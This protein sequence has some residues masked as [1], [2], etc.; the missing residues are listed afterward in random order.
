MSNGLTAL[1]SYTWSKS[2]DQSSA[3]R[4]NNTDIFT[5]DA[6]CIGCDYG[7]S[8]FNTPHRFVTST[9]WGIPFGRGKAVGT[10]MGRVADA[11]VGGWQLGSIITWQSGR[12]INMYAGWWDPPGTNTFGDTRLVASGG[13]PDLP[14]DHR[15]TEE[16]WDTST[17]YAPADG[18]FGNM[19]RNRMQG[20][21]TFGWDFSLHK[22]F[23]LF[24]S[25]R[26][27]FRFEAFNFPNHPRWG[28]PGNNFSTRNKNTFVDPDLQ[29]S[30]SFGRIRGT[31]GS[32]RQLQFALKYV[33]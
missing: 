31:R 32:M 2:L 20:P 3:I 8:S 30:P 27:E 1:I 4:G 13:D 5:N 26:L 19:S 18:S 33:F 23:A 12:A 15:N 25:H 21:S 11:F 16:W 14:A 29:P 9:L 10:N 7:Y 24:E 28:D 17:F 6:R 22:R